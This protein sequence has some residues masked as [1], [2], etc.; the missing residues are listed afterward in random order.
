MDKHL[1]MHSMKGFR[2][3]VVYF[4]GRPEVILQCP[5]ITSRPRNMEH[6]GKVWETYGVRSHGKS[7]AR[8]KSKKGEENFREREG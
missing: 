1:I 4:D 2:K 3:F 7:Q 5:F 8:L 6:I